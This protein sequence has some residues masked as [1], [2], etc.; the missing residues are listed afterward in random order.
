MVLL[1]HYMQT[2]GQYLIFFFCNPIFFAVCTGTFSE[3][4][5]SVCSGMEES[6]Q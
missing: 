3:W 2:P 5:E 1:S 4:C 6:A